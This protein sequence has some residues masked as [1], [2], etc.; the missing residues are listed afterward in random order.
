MILRVCRRC[1]LV[2][3]PPRRWCPRC[4]GASWRRASPGLGTVESVTHV[5]QG[6][7]ITGVSRP[8]LCTVR[9]DA[10]PAV[11]ATADPHLV[12]GAIA[13]VSNVGGVLRAEPIRE[14]DATREAARVRTSKTGT[15]VG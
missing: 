4:G 12:P 11:I 14:A 10:G 9:L 8:Y 15:D 2:A 5:H 6:F 7:G 1:D 3:F 13:L